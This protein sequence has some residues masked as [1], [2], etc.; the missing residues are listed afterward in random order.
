MGNKLKSVGAFLRDGLTWKATALLA[1]LVVAYLTADDVMPNALKGLH[2]VK[3]AIFAL[4]SA[5]ALCIDSVKLRTANK[6]RW[7]RTGTRLS[8]ALTTLTALMLAM[9]AASVWLYSEVDDKG[10]E[11][12]L[13]FFGLA[14]LLITIA[15]SFLY[16]SN[17]KSFEMLDRD[18]TES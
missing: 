5:T 15:S 12:R 17:L 3:A 9:A 18:L 2:A 7:Y 6:P 10:L 11:A 16:A 13:Y 8:D 4:T 14:A 1:L